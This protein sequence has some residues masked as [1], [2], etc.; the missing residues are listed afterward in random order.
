MSDLQT[1]LDNYKFIMNNKATDLGHIDISKDGHLVKVTWLK[2][3]IRWIKNVFT[4]G[5]VDQKV[6]QAFSEATNPLN[7]LPFSKFENIANRITYLNALQGE[8][9]A[10]V[11]E[12][13][14]KVLEEKSESESDEPAEPTQPEPAQ[15][16]KVEDKSRRQLHFGDDWD[17]SSEDVSDGEDK[18]EE[19]PKVEKKNF[20]K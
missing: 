7:P 15:P 14:R 17:S 1:R 10:K 16:P 3:V 8:R 6:Y 4:D 9:V 18:E 12:A 2:W 5:S 13:A 11:D 20:Q 19:E